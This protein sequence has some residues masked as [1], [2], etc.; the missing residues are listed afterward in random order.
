MIV[1]RLHSQQYGRHKNLIGSGYKK[2]CPDQKP[3]QRDP[4]QRN[5]KQPPVIIFLQDENGDPDKRQ[6]GYYRQIKKDTD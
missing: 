1:Y 4:D 5:D 3:R 2:E 6:K